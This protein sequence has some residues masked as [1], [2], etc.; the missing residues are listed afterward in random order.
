MDSPVFSVTIPL[1][2]KA[3]TVARTIESVLSQSYERFDL[4]VVDDGSEDGGPDLVNEFRDPRLRLIT[5]ENAGPAAA[6]NR[7]VL[8]SE[9]PLLAFIDAD[10]E[11]HP[12]YL[13]R[14]VDVFDREATLDCA[15]CGYQ[16]WPTGRDM[17]RVLAPKGLSAG[18]VELRWQ[19]DLEAMLL[20]LRFMQPL[21]TIIRRETFTALGGFYDKYRCLYG[22]DT[23]LFLKLLLSSR[24]RIVGATLASYHR[25][26]ST[27][28]VTSQGPRPIE[29]FLIDPKDVREACL[30]DRADLLAAVLEARANKTACMLGYWG[31]WRG[32]RRLRTAFSDGLTAPL[33][34]AA[35]VAGTPLAS[36]AGLTFRSVRNAVHS[37]SKGRE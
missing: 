29:P 11:W 8:A 5:Q 6:R 14:M 28:S 22:E 19:E 33:A 17:L 26:D 36:V 15:T 27:L 2:N 20:L 10:D 3:R 23:P 31:D 12:D 30:S 34:L 1:Y 37:I 9:A 16:E 32:A 25:E 21:T 7:G 24:V 18:R 13:E 4:I 35:F